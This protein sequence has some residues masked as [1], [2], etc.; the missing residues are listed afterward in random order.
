MTIGPD[1]KIPLVRMRVPPPPM[2]QPRRSRRR[3]IAGVLVEIEAPTLGIEVWVGEAFDVNVDGMGLM[4]PPALPL[5]TP[6]L[7]TFRLTEGYEFSRVPAAVLHREPLA[8]GGGVRFLPWADADRLRLV[9][10]LARA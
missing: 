5:T 3:A 1:R 7:L 8:G 6:V 2:S 9:E 4:L 10:F